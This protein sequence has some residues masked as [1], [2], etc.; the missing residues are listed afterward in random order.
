M[1]L[2]RMSVCNN[3]DLPTTDSLFSDGTDRCLEE[4]SSLSKVNTRENRGKADA[5]VP[6]PG[7]LFLTTI[8]IASPWCIKCLLLREM[9]DKDLQVII[10]SWKEKEEPIIAIIDQRGDSPLTKDIISAIVDISEVVKTW[11]LLTRYCQFC[12]IWIRSREEH[13]HP[14]VKNSIQLMQVYRLF[15]MM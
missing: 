8:L 10:S 11:A 4:F 15:T 3:I 6:E 9:N 13:I 12:G 2:W 5:L 1:I 7:L 14:N